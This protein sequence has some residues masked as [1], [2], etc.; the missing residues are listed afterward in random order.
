MIFC[1]SKR[2]EVDISP[3]EEEGHSELNKEMMPLLF[4]L[5]D[6]SPELYRHIRGLIKAY[7]HLIEH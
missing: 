4:K 1:S 5:K 6:N 3:K 2:P 7:F